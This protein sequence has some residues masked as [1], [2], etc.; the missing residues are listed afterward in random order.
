M[1]VVVNEYRSMPNAQ[2]LTRRYG[3]AEFFYI[4]N[5]QF[6]IFLAQGTHGDAEDMR[7]ARTVQGAMQ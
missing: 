2:G 1:Y 6:S 5:F 3:A 4:F 7:D